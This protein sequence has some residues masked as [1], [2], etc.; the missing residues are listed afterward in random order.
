MLKVFLVEDEI[1]M[2]EGIKKNVDWSGAGFEF[3]GEAGDG[4]LAYPLIQKAKPDILITDIKMPFMDGLELSRLVKQELPE[5]RIILLSG[6]DEFQYAKEAIEI[7]IAEYLVKPLTSVQLLDAVKKVEQKI[8]KD[9]SKFGENKDDEEKQRQRLFRHMVSGK[10]SFSEVLKEA[11]EQG[12]GLA[13]NAYNVM[14]LQIF[15]EEEET[16]FCEKVRTL[17]QK[18]ER[19]ANETT[20]II[21]AKQSREEYDFILKGTDEL[22]LQQL[23]DACKNELADFFGGEAQMEYVAALG[24]PVERFSELKNCYE[25]AS[26]SFSKR[27]LAERNQVIQENTEESGKP[28]DTAEL[29][30]GELNVAGMNRRQVEQFLYTGARQE[31]SAFVEGYF[32]EIGNSNVQSILLRQYVMMDL[33][34]VAVSVLEKSGYRAQDLVERCGDAKEMTAYLTTLEQT[35]AYVKKVFETVME[36]RETGSDRKYEG[37]LQKAKAYIEENFANDE[38]SLNAVAAAVSL[39]PSH[40]STIFGQ[41]MGE[42]FV[43]YLTGVRMEKAKQ[44]LKTTGMKTIDIAFEV[45]YRDAHY[46]SNLFKKTQGCTPREYRN[47]A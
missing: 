29:K 2:R 40:F 27:Y 11:K 9:K 15:S 12:I 30:L 47:R 32:S 23:T 7:G 44:L 14:L 19:V 20:N 1:I 38:I 6:Y 21:V 5:T 42:T 33:Y 22:P 37:V 34:V 41:E 18:L 13:A 10:Y 28:E 3:V 35:K 36:L 16:V 4:E 17:L 39:S 43:E 26:L 46:F 45:G 8:V 25:V 24:S 31:V